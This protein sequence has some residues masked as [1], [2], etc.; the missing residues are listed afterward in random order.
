[1]PTNQIKFGGNV[2][3]CTVERFPDIKKAQRKF[4]Q[5]NIPGRNG[6]LFF[7]SDAWESVVQSYQIYAGSDQY[8]SQEPW[9][10]L[11]K[12]LYL[13]G[14]Q[15]LTDT[16]DPDHFRKAVFNG[17]IDVQNS[18]NTHGRATIQFDCRPERFRF[19]G[20]TSYSY[21][22]QANSVLI[23]YTYPGH[24]TEEWAETYGITDTSFYLLNVPAPDPGYPL[25]EFDVIDNG[26]EKYIFAAENQTVNQSSVITTTSSDKTIS[27]DS[28]P[29]GQNT[30]QIVIPYSYI[31]GF[32][33]VHVNDHGAISVF[34]SN[35]MLN[36]KYMPSFPEIVLHRVTNHTGFEAVGCRIN[37]YCVFITQNNSSDP[38]YYFVDTENMNI[39][40]ASTLTGQRSLASNARMTAGLRLKSGTNVIYPGEY[41]DMTLTPNWWEL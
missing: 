17:P 21:T 9:T 37:G 3:P 34:G 27:V 4:R 15:T 12:C 23:Y 24:A 29:F 35:Q 18:W 38:A 25:Y 22:A 5:Y 19:D 13:D 41:Y 20:L 33:I 14:Y 8:G 30:F 2:L 10:D 7:Q 16:Y 39:T 31:D 26:Q 40:R 32:P 11:A 36:N 6:D 28:Y 1:M